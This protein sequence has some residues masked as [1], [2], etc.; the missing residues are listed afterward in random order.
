MGFT[1]PRWRP[2]RCQALNWADQIDEY[3]KHGP[4]DTLGTS[5]DPGWASQLPA[6][7]AQLAQAFQHARNAV[8]HQWWHAVAVR[9][10]Q[11]NG[12]QVNEWFWGP[13]PET[14]RRDKR[15][16]VQAYED[17]LQG[18]QVLNTLD[19]MGAVFWTKRRWTISGAELGQLGHEIGAPLTFDDESG[20]AGADPSGD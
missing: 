16:D 17:R 13:L 11:A 7:Q 5:R 15:G 4:K 8:H 20:A 18:R 10:S 19:E 14:G 6:D 1:R 9:I 2:R 12:S 3:L